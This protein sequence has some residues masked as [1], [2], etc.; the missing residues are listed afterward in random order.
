LYNGT[1]E[2]ATEVPAGLLSTASHVTNEQEEKIAD[3]Q[4]IK[5]RWRMNLKRPD[6]TE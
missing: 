4:N 6:D 3:A 1:R 5:S 2:G